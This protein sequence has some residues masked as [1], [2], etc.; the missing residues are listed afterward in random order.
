MIFLIGFWCYTLESAWQR[1]S[2]IKYVW[3]SCDNMYCE[4]LDVTEYEA[5]LIVF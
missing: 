4:G 2:D 5:N 3:R 1:F